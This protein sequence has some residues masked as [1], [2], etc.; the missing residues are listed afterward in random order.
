MHARTSSKPHTIYTTPNGVTLTPPRSSSPPVSLS[1]SCNQE[2]ILENQSEGNKT[3]THKRNSWEAIEKAEKDGF[4]KCIQ[5]SPCM[6]FLINVAK[7][8]SL[9]AL[10]QLGFCYQY[11]LRGGIIQKN[12]AV[13]CYQIAAEKNHTHAQ[14]LLGDCYFNGSGVPLDE[15]LAYFWFS[16]A[17]E[18]NHAEAQNKLGEC[19][20]DGLG[21]VENKTN[22]FQEY[23]KSANQNNIS[24]LKNLSSCYGKAMGTPED[25]EQARLFSNK[26]HDLATDLFV[27]A[28]GEKDPQLLF[29]HGLYFYYGLHDYPQDDDRAFILFKKSANEKHI[30]ALYYLGICYKKS[31]GTKENEKESFVCFQEAAK[32]GHALAQFHLGVCYRDGYGTIENPQEAFNSFYTS[33]KQGCAQAQN[34][35]G[36][37]Y[38]KNYGVTKTSSNKDIAIYWFQ[39]SLEQGNEEAQ[40]NYKEYAPEPLKRRDLEKYL[41]LKNLDVST[42]KIQCSL[43]FSSIILAKYKGFL[44][45]Y[46]L[47]TQLVNISVFM[48]YSHDA[49]KV[50]DDLTNLKNKLEDMLEQ[51]KL[52]VNED[53]F[54]SIVYDL[55]ELV[56]YMVYILSHAEPKPARNTISGS[57]KLFFAL[58]NTMGISF[59]FE[60]FFMKDLEKEIGDA[61]SKKF[62]AEKKIKIISYGNGFKLRYESPLHNPKNEDITIITEKKDFLTLHKL[63]QET[64]KKENKTH[65]PTQ[66][67]TAFHSKEDMLSIFKSNL[68]MD[69][70]F[71]QKS[72]ELIAVDRKK[73]TADDYNLIQQT[74]SGNFDCIGEVNIDSAREKITLFVDKEKGNYIYAKLN[75]STSSGVNTKVYSAFIV[76][77]EYGIFEPT[78]FGVSNMNTAE[79]DMKLK[80]FLEDILIENGLPSKDSKIMFG[81][82][83]T[84]GDIKKFIDL[85]ALKIPINV[86]TNGVPLPFSTEFLVNAFLTNK[87]SS[88]TIDDVFDNKIRKDGLG[89]FL[90]E[91]TKHSYYN[92]IDKLTLLF[93]FIAYLGIKHKDTHSKNFIVEIDEETGEFVISVLDFDKLDGI[94]SPKKTSQ[95]SNLSSRETKANRVYFGDFLDVVKSGVIRNRYHT[96][97]NN[98]TQM[99]N[100]EKFIK[101]TRGSNHDLLRYGAI[102]MRDK[103]LI[104]SD[105]CDQNLALVSTLKERLTQLSGCTS[106][107]E[108]ITFG[109]LSSIRNS[110]MGDLRGV[111]GCLA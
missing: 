93:V 99:S 30:E 54:N 60:S 108:Q 50:E 29:L 33:A 76:N 26:A 5:N 51:I 32:L 15:S 38:L 27:K 24:A 17:A 37:C 18:K 74:L 66:K 89:E 82:N 44:N 80:E 3:E 13:V 67:K 83:A 4:D 58:A 7:Q 79:K 39:K 14:Y 88:S 10:C 68:N 1:P 12:K 90:I 31:R 102:R 23:E 36:L 53:L 109:T 111:L 62:M 92:L 107:D 57:A 70:P 47:F 95:T 86:K 73:G 81:D 49:S 56:Q 85:F 42:N 20:Q 61:S 48:A 25:E 110:F 55:C 35:L 19:F 63:F 96:D 46:H 11:G 8:G 106:F 75:G 59:S 40:K 22:A 43:E 16:K 100:T 105:Q 78:L 91:F 77:P 71:V 84:L 101:F 94:D 97:G 45:K 21:V 104:S 2:N 28:R 65:A 34:A 87:P 6:Q 98:N 9:D 69:N 72:F 41:K 103:N 64:L 52:I